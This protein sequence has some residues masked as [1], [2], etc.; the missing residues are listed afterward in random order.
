MP[1]QPRNF[2]NALLPLLSPDSTSPLV[3]RSSYRQVDPLD[4]LDSV[5]FSLEL[6]LG[7]LAV[8]ASTKI[9]GAVVQWFS[10][11]R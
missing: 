4:D 8:A 7:N 3:G 5:L 1:K 11:S 9:K 2:R 6:E 10:I